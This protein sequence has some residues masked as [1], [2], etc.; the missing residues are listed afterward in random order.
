MASKQAAQVASEVEEWHRSK[1]FLEL[2][3][4]FHENHARAP[5]EEF[6]LAKPRHTAI[7]TEL[8]VGERFFYSFVSEFEFC[9]FGWSTLTNY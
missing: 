8:Q 9:F 4:K 3:R 2:M 6:K 7:I 1:E 5:K